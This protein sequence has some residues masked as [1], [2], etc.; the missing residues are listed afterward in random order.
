MGRISFGGPESVAQ[1][2][3]VYTNTAATMKDFQVRY[4]LVCKD[5]G[6]ILDD[7]LVYRWPYGLRWSLMLETGRRSLVGWKHKGR[8]NVQIQDQT[9]DTTMIALQGP[10]PVEMSP[11][12]SSTIL[13]R[14]NTTSRTDAVCHKECVVR[15][16]GYTGEDGF[17]VM[18][19]NAR[20]PPSGDGSRRAVPLCG[21]GLRDT[22]RH[23]A[24]M[25]L[26]GHE[27]DEGTNPLEAGLAWAVKFDKDDFI[28]RA[29]LERPAA[30]RHRPQLVGLVTDSRRP[31][32]VTRST[33]AARRS[34]GVL[35]A[36]GPDARSHR[37][38]VRGRFA[39]AGTAVEFAVKEARAR[40]RSWRSVLQTGKD[41]DS[42]STSRSRNLMNRLA[43][44]SLMLLI[45]AAAEAQQPGAVQREAMKKLDFLVGKWEGP[46][47]LTKIGKGKMHSLRQSEEVQYRLKGT[48][49]LWLRGPVA[50]QKEFLPEVT[51]TLLPSMRR[52]SSPT[53]RVGQAIPYQDAHDGRPKYCRLTRIEVGGQ[54]GCLG[55]QDT[56]EL[57]RGST[58]N[59]TERQKASGTRSPS[60]RPTARLGTRLSR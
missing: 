13:R 3:K 25:P 27:I 10:E 55:V 15:R 12:C 8:V 18:L 52:G 23:E 21:L 44:S 6:E 20:G 57:R 43:L 11:A 1:L 24:A 26:Y 32:R 51:I 19:P 58:H 9:L 14:S 46:L 17:E 5:D 36:T 37:D 45:P 7:I 2:E 29:A 16:T 42:P 47:P 40:D 49:L 48:V 41:P 35:E 31:R 56:E 22:L 53:I 34:A 54:G 4:G 60:S 28:G 38:R 30:G 33:P 50:G 59:E 39:K